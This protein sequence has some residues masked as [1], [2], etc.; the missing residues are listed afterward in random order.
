MH[1]ERCI[2]FGVWPYL[3][4]DA[5]REMAPRWEEGEK[6]GGGTRGVGG[7]GD[8]GSGSFEVAVLACPMGKG[9]MSTAAAQCFEVARLARVP[10]DA[11]ARVAASL[12]EGLAALRVRA[13]RELGRADEGVRDAEW[14]RRKKPWIFIEADPDLYS[15]DSWTPLGAALA[16]GLG[17][18]NIADPLLPGESDSEGGG[19]LEVRAAA[20][21]AQKRDPDAAAVPA[22]PPSHYP[23]LPAQRFWTPR[24]P[25]WWIVAH[26]TQLPTASGNGSD[27]SDDGGD[28]ES[29]GGGGGGGGGGQSLGDLMDPEE[30][31]RYGALREGRVVRLSPSLCEAANQWTPELVDVVRAVLDGMA[32]YRSGPSDGNGDGGVEGEGTRGGRGTG[33]DTQSDQS[34]QGKL[35]DVGRTGEGVRKDGDGGGE[36]AYPPA[37]GYHGVVGVGM[38]PEDKEAEAAELVARAER[39]AEAESTEAAGVVEA[40]EAGVAEM[41]AAER[42]AIAALEQHS[43]DNVFA[44]ATAATAATATAT[45]VPVAVAAAPSSELGLHLDPR[46]RTSGAILIAEAD[47]ADDAPGITPRSG[48]GGATPSAETETGAPT[49]AGPICN[50]VLK[51]A[52]KVAA[53]G[54]A[55]VPPATASISDTSAA[56]GP[57]SSS[58]VFASQPAVVA[59]GGGRGGA[60]GGGNKKKKRN[61]GA[62][63]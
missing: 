54:R 47:H 40:T 21:L 7:W 1:Q 61:R 11:A 42:A 48:A 9:A 14:P 23:Q 6:R 17:V 39:A 16:E 29:D 19:S 35:N 50:T 20:A 49:A 45:V 8:A 62:V 24:E 55:E 2:K 15:A 36:D 10:T 51:H 34:V 27:E 44:A 58:R 4:V 63:K 31:A 12:T 38:Q 33:R 28:K 18:G 13:E 59:N 22:A 60:G 46:S 53:L 26:P 3:E 25:D 57:S 32:G 5:L 30:L 52:T 41:E 37:S 56:A 43:R